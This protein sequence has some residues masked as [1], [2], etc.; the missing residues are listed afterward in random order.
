MQDIF[1][2]SENALALYNP[3][4]RGVERPKDH[5]Y[6]YKKGRGRYSF[7]YVERG[8]IEYIFTTQ[9]VKLE[10]G[11]VLF[12]PKHLPSSVHYTGDANAI[13]ILLFD[14]DAET[15]PRSFDKLIHHKGEVAE[16][17][18]SLQGE[19]V[20]DAFFLCAKIFELLSILGREQETVPKKYRSI[21]PALRK[22][23]ENFRENKRISYYAQLC[24]MSE[25]NLR[26]LFK[27]FT[28]SSLIEYR[29]RIRI[30][31]ARKL[32]D[33]GEFSVAEA[34]YLVGFNN[35]SF[36]YEQMKAY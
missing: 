28:G 8:S 22:I 30:T 19:R 4:F 35:M 3:G 36:F 7:V 23:R 31:E 27:E 10:K 26:L 29:N 20:R 13:K 15:M 6:E 25:S 17:F 12:I 14:A 24:H 33:S 1:F 2:D 5:V 21:L 34:A 18:R 11:G 16:I 9:T 32:I